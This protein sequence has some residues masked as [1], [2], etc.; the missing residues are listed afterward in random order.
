MSLPHLC[1]NCYNLIYI[2]VFIAQ[3]LNFYKNI[4]K[5]DLAIYYE[6]LSS[7]KK[8]LYETTGA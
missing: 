6:M 1:L 8:L 5:G 4:E 7:G 3:L 2:V